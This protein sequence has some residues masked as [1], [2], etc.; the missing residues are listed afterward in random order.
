MSKLPNTLEEAIEQALAATKAALNDGYGRIQVELV[1]PEIALRAQSLALEFTKLFE[2]YGSSLKVMFPDMGAAALARRDWQEFPFQ[3]SDLG[4]SRTPV[5]TKISD[6]DEIFLVVCPSAVEVT[7]VERLCNLAGDRPVVILIPQLEDV[8]IVGIGYAAR[9]LRERFLSTLQSCY[10]VQPLE[11]G[12]ILRNYP[13]PWQV[14]WE[15]EES[16]ELIAELP[17]KPVGDALE[18]IFQQ[19]AGD[20]EESGE[21]DKPAMPKKKG[22]FSSLQQFLRA[23]SQ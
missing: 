20:N 4:S 14:W 3:V 12:A 5:D 13:S 21:E 18:Q 7:L 8:S 17:Q 19:A 11:G 2:D 9:Q 23:L 6:D 1:F 15:K 10:Y 22:V 16:Y